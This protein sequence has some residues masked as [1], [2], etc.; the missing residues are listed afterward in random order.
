[1]TVTWYCCIE[2]TRASDASCYRLQLQVASATRMNRTDDES[3]VARLIVYQLSTGFLKD[4]NR[5]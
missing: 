2:L 5:I 4:F 1:M 3:D